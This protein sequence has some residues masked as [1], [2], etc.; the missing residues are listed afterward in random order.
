MNKEAGSRKWVI[1]FSLLLVSLGL[2]LVRLNMSFWMDEIIMMTDFVQKPWLKIITDVPYPNNHI[3]Y[4][5]LAKLSV[6]FFG[7]K[8]WSARLP[9]V[10][11]GSLT[12]P[13]SYLIFRKKISELAAAAAGLFLALNYWAVWFSQDARGY[14]ALILLGLAGTYF[15]LEHLE[16]G[17]WRSAVYYI[18]AAGFSIQFH[19]Y[20][21]FLIGGQLAWGLFQ[22]AR[23]KTR[24]RRLAPILAAV[25]LG[26]SLYLPA[27][28]QLYKFAETR[29]R[30]ILHRGLTLGLVRDLFMMLAGTRHLKLTLLILVL[31]LPGFFGLAKK[32]AGFSATYVVAAAALILFTRTAKVF[33][34]ARFLAFLLPFFA[35][36]L[37]NTLE[38][39]RQL[40]RPR[41]RPLALLLAFLFL[42]IVFS[43]LA[44][45]LGNYYL[46]GKQG[47]RDAAQYISQIR[48]NEELICYGIICKELKYYYPKDMTGVDEKKVLTPEFIKN[49]LII[50]RVVD[51]TDY[52]LKTALSYCHTER[53]WRSAGYKE[54][55]LLLTKCP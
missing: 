22:A 25:V 19:L 32:W 45:G 39:G 24:I 42:P 14:S 5:L 50:S 27:A 9:A 26:L 28:A 7:E 46:L 2:R 18:L 16:R 55:I 11:F 48:A 17:D 43:I 52:N 41:S 10:V 53:M 37:I 20:G 34:Y 1:F 35:I 15:F 38:M 6:I 31:A 36:C 44:L 54:N 23:N 40:L 3:L 29:G 51:W 12:P 21:L 30:I 13:V 33:I 4:T 47:F 8:E 49:K